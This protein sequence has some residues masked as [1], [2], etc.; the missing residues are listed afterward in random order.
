M[1]VDRMVMLIPLLAITLGIGVILTLILTLH[2]AKIRE[3]DQRHRERMA[4][5]DRG[6]EV[7]PVDSQPAR[8]SS[9]P[10]AQGPSGNA[11]DPGTPKPASRYLLRGL[12]WLGIGLAIALARSNPWDHSGGVIGWIAVAVG[13]ACLIY[14]AVEGNRAA[15]SGPRDPPPAP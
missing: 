5:I 1:P 3:L 11:Y 2:R 14:Y 4:A 6:L 8:N 10:A 15:G 13:V 12:I 9:A 7:P